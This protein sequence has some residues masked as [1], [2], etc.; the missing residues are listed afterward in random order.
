MIRMFHVTKQ[1]TRDERALDDV[2]LRLG[3]GEFAFLTGH[4]GAGK[5]TLMRLLFA[6][7]KPTHGQVV[8]AGHNVDRLSRSSIPILRRNIGVI[9]QDF[10]LLPRRTVFDNVAFTL[11]V[12]GRPRREIHERVTH[13]LRQVGLEHKTK[14]LPL[15]L[16]GGEQ[17]RVAIAR[18]LVNE[19][20]VVLADEPTG[21]LDES[22]ALDIM[23]LLESTNA[24]GTTVVVAT[25]DL[26]MTEFFKKRVITLEQGRLVGDTG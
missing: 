5:S 14:S 12:L 2:S 7:E 20:P 21:N 18:A 1:Y 26:R 8:V 9:F 19:P 10:K 17:Q 22:L 15:R 16:S 3:K 13:V 23:R 11:H 25:H 6:A 24:R 4:S